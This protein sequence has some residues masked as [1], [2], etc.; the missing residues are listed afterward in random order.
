MAQD[1]YQQNR[2]TITGTQ[3]QALDQARG[4]LVD[5][6]RGHARHDGE[7]NFLEDFAGRAATDAHRL[8]F[9]RRFDRDAHG[10]IKLKGKG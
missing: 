9:V 2:L 5:F 4:E 10:R 6:A 3:A 8:D 1:I 7:G